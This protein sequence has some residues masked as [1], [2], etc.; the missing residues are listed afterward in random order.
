M[1]PPKAPLERENMNQGYPQFSTDPEV[2]VL[3]PEDEISLDEHIREWL[4]N[5]PGYQKKSENPTLRM[6]TLKKHEKILSKKKHIS[7]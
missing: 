1:T 2:Y 4:K 5:N 3:F 7:S 6:V